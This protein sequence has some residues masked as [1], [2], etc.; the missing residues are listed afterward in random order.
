MRKKLSESDRIEI[1]KTKLER[2]LKLASEASKVLL[3]SDNIEV[4]QKT[5]SESYLN[6]AIM[7]LARS[8]GDLD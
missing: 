5:F 6:N 4:M 8:L 3:F 7:F 2:A 1:A